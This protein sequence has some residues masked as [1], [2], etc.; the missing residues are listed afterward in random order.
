MG[1][2]PN[3][4]KVELEADMRRRI[5]RIEDAILTTLKY[6]GEKAVVYARN[7][8]T[9]QDQTGNLRSS[10]GYVIFKNGTDVF[11]SGFD[12]VK[13]G[14]EGAN[15]GQELA[16]KVASEIDASGYVLVVVAGMD[17][18][19]YVETKG[20]DVISGSELKIQST[21]KRLLNNIKKN[22]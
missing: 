6:A 13:H 8:E 17:Y 22:V 1:M 10:I 19:F 9:Y 12:K 21:L 11:S 7:L 16:R 2:R 15:K 4:S 14:I 3:F 20:Y 18:A 5:D